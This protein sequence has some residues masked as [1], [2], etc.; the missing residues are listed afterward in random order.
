MQ[1]CEVLPPDTESENKKAG[2]CR[3][4]R[5]CSKLTIHLNIDGRISVSTTKTS[6]LSIYI[7]S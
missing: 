1:V 3:M 6:S 5:N 7:Y 2:K 4:Q